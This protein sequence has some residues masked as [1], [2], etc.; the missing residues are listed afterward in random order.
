MEQSITP[1]DLK[2]MLIGDLPWL[3]LVEVAVRTS[4]MYLY[5]LVIVRLMGKRGRRQLSPFDFLVIIALGSAVGDPM[6]YATVPML[7]GMAVL[8]TIVALDRLLSYAVHTSEWLE[9]FVQGMPGRLVLNG[10]LDVPSINQETVSREEVFALLR[11]RGI[12]HLGE[13]ERVYIEQSG[14]VSLYRYS[15]AEVRPGLPIAPPWELDRPITLAA[16]D[17]VPS[18]GYY[19]CCACGETVRLDTGER[20]PECQV[21]GGQE[22]TTAT[23]RPVETQRHT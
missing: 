22:W 17:A 1:L 5:A 2:R 21:C 8:T 13:V 6:L 4:V 9:K 14:E 18:S 15:P 20:L 7:P 19:A 10:R 11:G 3:F 16:G 12:Q 23:A